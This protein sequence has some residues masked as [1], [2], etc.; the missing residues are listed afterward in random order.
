MLQEIFKEADDYAGKKVQEHNEQ[1]FLA[2]I[3]KIRNIKAEIQ[4]YLKDV[5][6]ATLL[7]K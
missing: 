1:V 5:Q 2:L 7:E 3:P 4:N 6:N